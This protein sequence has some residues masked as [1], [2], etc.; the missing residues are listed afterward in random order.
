MVQGWI[1]NTWIVTYIFFR[2]TIRK[3]NR[4][5]NDC[6]QNLLWHI[7]F[8]YWWMFVNAFV[9]RGRF[10]LRYKISHCF[11][12]RLVYEKLLF[13]SFFV[14]IKLLSFLHLHINFFGF[15]RLI[16]NIFTCV[17]NILLMRFSTHDDLP[18]DC[19]RKLMPLANKRLLFWFD[20]CKWY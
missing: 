10:E 15:E 8:M 2:N 9:S 16:Q 18:F 14:V 12:L 3:N 11:L 17:S 19:F 7:V 6:K 1:E 13:F 5:E 4:R 20:V